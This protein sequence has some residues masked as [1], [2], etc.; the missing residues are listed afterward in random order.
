MNIKLVREMIRLELL[1]KNKQRRKL[2][3]SDDKEVEN[4]DELTDEIY[5]DQPDEIETASE[6]TDNPG[7]VV[8]PSNR[9]GNIVNKLFTSNNKGIETNTLKALLDAEKNPNIEK[10]Q[11]DLKEVVYDFYGSKKFS[12]KQCASIYQNIYSNKDNQNYLQSLIDFEFDKYKLSDI[13]NL[14]E[15]LNGRIGMINKKGTFDYEI[16][17]NITPNVRYGIGK[18]EM[19]LLSYLSDAKSGATSRHDVV[20]ETAEYEVKQGATTEPDEIAFKVKIRRNTQSNAA[21]KKF[22][23]DVNNF[24]KK[25]IDSTKNMDEILNLSSQYESAYIFNEFI[26]RKKDPTGFVSKAMGGDVL[27]ALGNLDDFYKDN[28]LYYV[29]AIFTGLSAIL[30]GEHKGKTYVN[31]LD[32][33]RPT[34]R[35][36]LGYELSEFLPIIDYISGRKVNGK[37]AEYKAKFNEKTLN[38]LK[39]SFLMFS[40]KE[41]GEPKIEI[42][43]TDNNN[44]DNP[45]INKLNRNSGK[46]KV[47]PVLSFLKNIKEYSDQN[48][49]IKKNETIYT[50]GATSLKTWF[51]IY[52]NMTIKEYKNALN[53]YEKMLSEINEAVTDNPAIKYDLIKDLQDSNKKLSSS[54]LKYEKLGNEENLRQILNYKIFLDFWKGLGFRDEIVIDIKHYDDN[55]Q[56]KHSKQIINTIGDEFQILEPDNNQTVEID[57]FF[58]DVKDDDVFNLRVKNENI[59]EQQFEDIM[60]AK[61][62]FSFL[63]NN[64]G[65][66]SKD[67]NK[68]SNINIDIEKPAKSSNKT[69]NINIVEML[70]DLIDSLLN[71]HKTIYDEYSKPEGTK[72]DKMTGGLIYIAEK[73]DVSSFRLTFNN[74]S[75]NDYEDNSLKDVDSFNKF[76]EKNKSL[77]IIKDIMGDDSIIWQN[78]NPSSQYLLSVL[79]QFKDGLS[80]D[81]NEINETIKNIKNLIGQ[82]IVKN[83]NKNINKLLKR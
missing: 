45:T 36:D 5:S 83:P 80:N 7:Q 79:L 10:H 31:P 60:K 72:N 58:N 23:T 1:Y 50:I 81:I 56:L 29:P 41:T 15:Y 47:T 54:Y 76:I 43:D 8:I 55:N 51:Q 28:D 20:G 30:S 65:K 24:I 11:N 39:K 74:T 46:F 64:I 59:S 44:P 4:D 61:E 25:F 12:D 9:T 27:N 21:Q 69:S 75:K 6:Q 67:Q 42:I 82:L 57:K 34:T 70:D 2:F 3:E 13:N 62:I 26:T 22:I 37:E 73:G 32:Y 68:T 77:P 17:R 16:Y 19:L 33:S 52:F 49:P 66:S 63:N 78:Y 35:Y 14:L 40:R 18:G 53:F 71:V 38:K 48:N